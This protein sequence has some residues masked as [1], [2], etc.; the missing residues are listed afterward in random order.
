[1]ARDTMRGTAENII[2]PANS[3]GTEEKDD[4]ASI[5]RAT[6]MCNENDE[7]L[8]SAAAIAFGSLLCQKKPIDWCEAQ[9]RDPTDRLAI[10]LLR[11]KAKRGDIPTD[12]LKNKDTNP[13]E[14]RRLLGQYKLTALSEHDNRKLLV[15][16]PTHEPASR[17]NRKPGRYERLLEDEPIRVHVP[18]MLR[19]WV[20]DRA[21]KEAVHHGEK[22]TLAMLERYYYWVGMVS[23]VKWWIRRCY[24]CQ[25]RNKT[26]ATVRWPLVYLPLSSGPDQMVAFD[27][28][29]PLPRTKQGN[30]HNLLVVD[31]CSRHAEGYALSVDEKT[32][33]SYAAKLVHDYIPLWDCPHTFLSDRGP[34][35]CPRSAEKSSAC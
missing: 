33:Q 2:S 35:S 34:E 27:L 28:L 30:E 14:V 23:S 32:A 9:N 16:R 19:P 15:R 17:P 26:R 31:L 5:S 11:A 1:M 18:L 25:A 12:Q 20:M 10:K 24:A 13:D 21:H 6:E 4:I 22:V 7:G 29:G 8:D 3:P